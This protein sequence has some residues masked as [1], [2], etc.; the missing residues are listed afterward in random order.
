VVDNRGGGNGVIGAGFVANS[1]PDGYTLMLMVAPAGTHTIN[2]SLMKLPY[3]TI[4]NFSTFIKNDIAKWAKVVREAG[5]TV[6]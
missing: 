6:N 4:H 2:P 3:D 5:I 1:T